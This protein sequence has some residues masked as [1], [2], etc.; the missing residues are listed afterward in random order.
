MRPQYSTSQSQRVL[1]AELKSQIREVVVTP[2]PTKAAIPKMDYSPSQQDENLRRGKPR[3]VLFV[4]DFY[5]EEALLGVVDYA[6]HRNWELITNMRF[7]GKLPTDEATDGILVTGFSERVQEWMRKWDGTHAVHIG[8]T[9]Q[10]IRLPWVDVDYD[11]AAEEGARHLLDLGHL[12]FAFYSL[13]TLENTR[14]ARNKFTSELAKAE[15]SLEILDFEAT[16]GHGAMDIPREERLAW[17]AE[18]LRRMKKPLAVMTDDDRRSLEVVAACEKLGLRIP[19]D[20]SILGCENRNVEVSMSRVPLSSVDLNWRAV[21]RRA[22]EELDAQMEGRK[23]FTDS[24]VR[25]APRGV[26]ARASTATFV[27]DNPAI[28]RALLFIREHAAQQLK[29]NELARTAGMSERQFRAEFKKLVGHSPRRE[30][31][32]ARLAAATRLLRDTE[33]KLD[34][35]AVESGFGSAKKLC[36]VFAETYVMTPTAWRTQARKD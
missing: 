24:G 8:E 22:A 1:R 17:L 10:N 21:G 25:V 12:N 2:K 35:I 29:M 5:Q 9:P 33:L 28:T 27:T 4:T 6:R 23:P 20:V 14:R 7:H 18:R 16:H 11:L 30:I 36:E 31:H 3:R 26:V 34:A 13:V 19:E 15:R 32:R